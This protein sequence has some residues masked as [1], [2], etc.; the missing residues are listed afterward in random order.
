MS[1]RVLS[2][3]LFALVLVAAGGGR[4]RAQEIE[5]ASRAPRFLSTVTKSGERLDASNAAILQRRVSL[6]LTGVT[7]KTALDEIARQAHVELLY[8]KNVVQLERQVSVEA[9]NLT[10]A[11]ALTEVLIG[12]GLDVL[13]SPEGQLALAKKPLARMAGLQ[14]GSIAG[15][16]TDAKTA[17]ALAGATVLVEG[18]SRSTTTGNDGR[19]R[20]AEVVPGTYTVR[21]RYI[22][23]TPGLASAT[24]SADQ[25]AAADLALEKSPQRLDEVVTTGTMIP[26][27]VK[28]LPSPISVFTADQI[29]QQHI[30][31]I[32]Q[33]FRGQVAGAIAWD[34]GQEDYQS[35]INV[36][37]ASSITADP[38]IKTFVDGVEVADPIYIAMIDPA[39]I[40][41]IE[42]IRG[43]QA[44]TL[45]GAG[46]LN[47]VMQ[48]FTKRGRIGLGRPEIAAKLSSGG[49][50]GYGAT[51]TAFQ[52]D[53][54]VTLSGGADRTSYSVSG[55]YRH[56]G[57]WLPNYGSSTGG[58]AV[59]AQTTQGPLT[60]S[61]S[62]RYNVK[63]FTLTWDPRFRAYTVFSQPS[64]QDEHFHQQTYGLTAEV[65]ATP[66]WRHTLAL[67]FDQTSF[68]SAQTQPRLTRPAD[69]LLSALA[70]NDAKASILYHTDWDL[71]LGNAATAVATAGLNYEAFDHVLTDAFAATHTSGLLNGP[72]FATRTP[73]TNTGF[74]AQ[75]TLSLVNQVFIT[76]GLR[77]ERNQNLGQDYGTAWS[78]RVGLS[79]VQPL[80]GTT[81]KIRGSYGESIR[82]PDP[83]LRDGSVTPFSVVVANPALAPERQRGVDAG[84][85]VNVG[86]ASLSA[87]YYNQRAINLIDVVSLP[88]G[89]NSVPR[90][91]NQNVG[92]VQNEGWEF[93]ASLPVGRL[94]LAGTYAITHSTVQEL[95]PTF[96]GDY[97]IGDQVLRIPKSAGG[98]SITYALPRTR[99]M[100]SMTH[101]GHWTEVDWLALY[102]VFFGGQPYRGSNRAYWMEY[103]TVTKVAVGA[104][105]VLTHQVSAFVRVENIGN[106]SRAE[107]T[108]VFISTP[109]S[110]LI[111][112]N[113]RY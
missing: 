93:E 61:T 19:Y 73:W 22:G 102:G 27:E 105:Q 91:E 70:N 87:T 81:I 63:N 10:V 46:A 100:V 71:P 62:L 17:G 57:Q 90:S 44:S 53:N 13:V 103:P 28:A 32:D 74:F 51:S 82:A 1:M 69:T 112:V 109:R 20:I 7:V 60:L 67:G 38:A 6:D 48:I 25:E 8:S 36:R 49:I 80:G 92:R 72:I 11:A 23:Y 41:R 55:S 76:G 26:T 64:Y 98:A 75:T 56:L 40:E 33:L 113:V 34:G 95:G 58:V 97:Q 9:K 50:G 79:Y 77:G 85:D 39:S 45:Y 78:P 31:R 35:V 101:I 43:P 18:T 42:L 30:Q 24:V 107:Q 14:A 12:A 99:L 84:I 21:A 2:R 5:L 66:H 47:G 106:N 110:A 15:R 88:P 65:Q 94:T 108:N 37:G 54:A 83:G 29:E 16:I 86:R 96:S 52:T 104:S 111:G 3:L 89:A 59:G 4:A 68:G